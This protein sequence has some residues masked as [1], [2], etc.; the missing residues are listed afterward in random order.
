MEKLAKH[1]LPAT[2][3]WKFLNCPNSNIKINNEFC[4]QRFMLLIRKF[5]SQILIQ[6]KAKC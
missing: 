6:K 5:S 4:H 3:Y 1:Q 2:A